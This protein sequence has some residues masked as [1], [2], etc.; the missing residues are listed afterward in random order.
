MYQRGG[1]ENNHGLGFNDLVED[2]LSSWP[3]HAWIV[4]KYICTN[5]IADITLFKNA[6]L[7]MYFW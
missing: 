3:T 1:R 6:V 5:V 7:Q 4:A 2:R